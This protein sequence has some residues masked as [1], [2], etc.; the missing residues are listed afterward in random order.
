[1][2]FFMQTNGLYKGE[3]KMARNKYPEETI[4][5]ILNTSEKL[6]LEKGYD[7]TSLQDIINETKLSKGAIYHHF[8]SK[9]DIFVKIFGRMGEENA[10]FLSK[11][12]D[13]KTLNGSE[14]LRKIFY[15]ALTSPLN[16]TMISVMPYLLD[17]P[18]F[19]ALQVKD[20]YEEVAPNY[21]QPI[22][23]QGIFDGSIHAE[24]PKELA[25]AIMMLGNIWLNPLLLPSS[26][27]EMKARCHVFIKLLQGVGIDLPED[28]IVNEYTAYSEILCKQRNSVNENQ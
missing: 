28:E 15:E 2:L 5:L 7:K 11:T 27:E 18:K 19:L 6:F 20:I 1:M 12:R 17:N 23:E 13:D 24:H 4:K 3:K 21:I 25:E 26:I 8:S 14:K 10:S 22:L 9:E 16:H